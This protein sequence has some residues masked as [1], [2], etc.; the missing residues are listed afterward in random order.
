MSTPLLDESNWEFPF[1]WRSLGLNWMSLDVDQKD[2][3]SPSNSLV[4]PKTNEKGVSSVI[5]TPFK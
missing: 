5:R 1:Y 3:R 2:H 4:Y